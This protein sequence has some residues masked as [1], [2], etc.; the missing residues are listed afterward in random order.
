MFRFCK[1]LFF[2]EAVLFFQE[3]L[4]LW[5]MIKGI[6]GAVE[7]IKAMCDSNFANTLWA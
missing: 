2:Q 4:V 1:V 5:I 7:A 3:A 6:Q